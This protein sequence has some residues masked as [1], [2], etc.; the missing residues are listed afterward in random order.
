[1]EFAREHLKQLGWQEGGGLG[2]EQHGITE[3]LKPKLKFDNC[4][5]GHDP[6]KE[7]THTWWSEAY[8]S[9]ASNLT[10]TEASDGVQLAGKPKKKKKK[11]KEKKA[12]KSTYS[13]FVTGGMLM[14]D[15]I[16]GDRGSDGEAAAEEET[17][18]EDS[19][20]SRL[21]DEQLLEACGGRTAHKGA[22]HGHKM[23]G[24]LAR[25]MAQEAVILA[26]LQSGKGEEA[27]T[28]KKKKKRKH[29]QVED[30][31]SAD[32]E[33]KM[34]SAETNGLKIEKKKKKKR[35]LDDGDA[36][37]VSTNDDSI[38]TSLPELKKQKKK[39]KTKRES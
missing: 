27:V 12:L 39:K 34:N 21:S 28:K 38:D 22:R 33:C 23:D 18:T 9:A 26:K 10:V 2:R 16:T 3:A 37:E 15:R 11:K 36:V 17:G 20:A 1:M 4:G 31:Q 7:F 24:K 6:A 5:I 35:K 30:S 29:E 25:I 8:N 14:G 32:A 13:N 19:T